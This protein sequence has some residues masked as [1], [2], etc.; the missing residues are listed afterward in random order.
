MRGPRAD[1]GV[2]FYR[3]SHT[4]ALVYEVFRRTAERCQEFRIIDDNPPA[5]RGERSLKLLISASPPINFERGFP[6]RGVGESPPRRP[7]RDALE[8]QVSRM[9]DEIAGTG[10]GRP[11]RRVS[12]TG[13]VAHGGRAEPGT[14][15]VE[16]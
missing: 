4:E 10:S 9:A 1:G 6:A 3:I 5:D 2:R 8:Q 11:S 13:M 14:G 7:P 15:G 12:R 16:P